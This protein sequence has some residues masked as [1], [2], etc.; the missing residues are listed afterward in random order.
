VALA[1]GEPEV[2]VRDGAAFVPRLAA[3]S[4]EP[5]PLSW[6]PDGTVLITG[7]TGG[8]GAEVAR[9]LVTGH[10]VRRLLLTSRRGPDAP[11]AAELRDELTALGAE[12][13][14]RSCDV[15]DRESV[16]ALLAAVPA[17]A[18]LTAVLHAAGVPSAGDIG[19]LT[20]DEVDR[21]FAPK[22]DGAWHL[23][24]LAGDLDAFVLF[25]S[26]ASTVLA[27]GQSAYAAAN[28]FLDA[29]A[30]H[31]RATG[32][33]ALSIAWGAWA[34]AGMATE[35]TE[36]DVRRLGRLGTPPM[37]AAD[38]LALL[39][40]C[41][42]APDAVLAPIRLD[43]AALRGRGSALPPTLRGLVRTAPPRR[44]SAATGAVAARLAALPG[45]EREAYLLSV[46]CDQVAAVLGFASAAA[47]E[48][49]RAFQEMGFDSLTSVEL[50]NQLGELVGR[51]LTATIVFDHPTPAAL[52]RRLHDLLGS[53]RDAADTV[54]AEIDRFEGLLAAAAG[55]LNGSTA[56]VTA[57]LDALVRKWA[58][59]TAAAHPDTAGADLDTATDDELFAVLD[60]EL[61]IS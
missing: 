5:A 38:A 21:V 36:A 30:E 23:H 20:D 34:D 15:T 35:L 54:L 57:R 12:V 25:S 50:R 31:R 61:G 6:N 58:D 4:A 53:G 46:V 45:T 7:G 33:P 8:L 22:V 1:T 40:A 42:S 56:K 52:A 19:S 27:A 39:D 11:G 41:L 18:P 49:E 10:G 51:T 24:E 37:P 28:A 13:S 43:R 2:A 47:V 17:D 55:G 48:P 32:R 44:A 60:D 29:L 14:V 9:H 26:A 3:A 16:R 59:T